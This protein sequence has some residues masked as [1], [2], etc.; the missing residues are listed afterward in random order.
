MNPFHQKRLAGDLSKHFTTL[1]L[2]QCAA[3]HTAAPPWLLNENEE[4]VFIR[5]DR[6]KNTTEAIEKALQADLGMVFDESECAFKQVLM[7][8]G[9]NEFGDEWWF[10]V[11]PRLKKIGA[12]KYW[13]ISWMF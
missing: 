5:Q 6:A 7:E 9:K 12:V 2:K 1:A 3:T 11:E 4:I 8:K 10:E 13:K